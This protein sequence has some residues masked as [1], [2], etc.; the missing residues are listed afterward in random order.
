MKKFALLFILMVFMLACSLSGSTSNSNDDDE[1][2]IDMQPSKT[3]R[4]SAVVVTE[5]PILI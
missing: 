5:E 2:E 1:D 3:S 4:E